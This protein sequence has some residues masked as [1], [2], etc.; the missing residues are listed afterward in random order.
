PYWLRQRWNVCSLMPSFWQT[1]PIVCPA[2]SSASAS[3]SL[4]MICSGV[5]RLPFIENLLGQHGRKDSHNNWT[6]FWGA[7]H[8]RTRLYTSA[9]TSSSFCTPCGVR[10]LTF[11]I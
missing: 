1:C 3:R 2:F 11:R 6:T 7:D 5:C 9:Y 8:P 10:H 4:L